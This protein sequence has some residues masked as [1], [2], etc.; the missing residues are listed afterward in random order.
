[1]SSGTISR[2]NMPFNFPNR[3]T[4]SLLMPILAS[5][6]GSASAQMNKAPVAG[7][8]A[9]HSPNVVFI[10]A[11]DLGWMDTSLY[12][13]KFYRTPNIDA[14]ARRGMSF[15][16][17]YTANPLCSPTR[18]SLMTGLDPARIGLTAPQ[19]NLPNVNFQ[20]RVVGRAS[21]EVKAL[22]TTSATR[23]ATSYFTLAEAFKAQGYATGH[24]GK[25]HLGAAPYSPL[26]QGFDV[27]LPNWPGAGPAGS[28]VAPWK[29]PTFKGE[30]GEH[31][32]DRMAKEA[33]NYIVANKD[34]PFFLNYWAFSV[35]SPFDAKK[36]LIEKYR[37]GADDA[38][39]QHS[40]TYA[41]MVES[42]DDAVGTLV[43]TLDEQKL[44]D[45]TLLIFTSDNGGNMYD[46]V[47]GT[48]PTSNAPL[49]GGKATIYE[50]GTRVPLIV[51]WP[52]KV[53]PGT[54]S[55]ALV[56]SNDFYPTL[57]D[58]LRFPA[59]PEQKFDGI[60]MLPALQ[61]KPIARDA[62]FCHFP[63]YVPATGAIP[64]TYV[65]QD[66]WK[67]IRF[68]ADNADQSDRF[69]LYNLRDDIGET[70]NLAAAMPEKTLQLNA[71]I[72]QFLKDREVVVPLPNPNYGKTE[73]AG[74]MVGGWRASSSAKLNLAGN[75]LDLAALGADPFIAVSDLPG[76]TGPYTVEMR[77]R[78][79][80]DAKG[81]VFWS[82]APKTGF[83]PQRVVNFAVKPDGAWQ[84][85]AIALPEI[86]SIRNVRIDPRGG[87]G[88]VAFES[89][90]VLDAQKKVVQSWTFEAK[91]QPE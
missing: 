21:P 8:K 57:L 52:L 10:L 71:L 12:G 40:P 90:R 53:R 18:A 82:V 55:D 5:S 83:G 23:L 60:S 19:G 87:R 15:T 2:S 67:L 76:A 20:A 49:R 68:Y 44:T 1:M 70:K 16:R 32:E 22:Q 84:N 33:S 46:K 91:N 54:Q 31:I 79:N 85:Y 3:L 72:S 69:E 29:F 43:K 17:A 35:H 25:W 41:A 86:G 89:I 56:N 61:G 14:L 65:H 28:F 66:D 59:Q 24:F 26:E 34:K 39:P 50:G 13:S 36:S 38:N 77:M 62:I 63:H 51:S 78:S 58:A 75:R 11:D 30:P 45:N 47:D 37:A 42:L 6:F 74:N 81:Q 7:A 48:T 73:G 80:L 64:S 27:D 9:P 88:E 4:F